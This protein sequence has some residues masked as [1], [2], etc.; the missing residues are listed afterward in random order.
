MVPVLSCSR[1]S[2][3]AMIGGAIANP[4][5]DRTARVATAAPTSSAAGLV[6]YLNPTRYRIRHS[7]TVNRQDAAF[8]Y[9][10]AWLPVPVSWPE[11][12]ISDLKITPDTPPLS[13]TDCRDKVAKWYLDQVRQLSGDRL[14]FQLEYTCTRYAVASDLNQLRQQ[15]WQPYDA[16]APEVKRYLK[17]EARVQSDQADLQAIA[18]RYVG[19]QRPW[20]EVAFNLYTWVLNHVD[21][22][23]VD[24]FKGAAWCFTE[25][26]G[27]C[28]DYSALFVALC[29]AAGIP[30][31]LCPGFHLTDR[32]NEYHVWAEFLLPTGE[33]IPVDASLGDLEAANRL[34][35]FGNL[36]NKRLAVVKTADLRLPGQS[37]G[38]DHVEF[39]QAGAVWW[40]IQHG[41]PA[42]E[43]N[44][45]R[46]DG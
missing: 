30:A 28:G 19:H 20:G 15:P 31:R 1:R 18:A 32:P 2:A 36:N 16:E 11:Q 5:A 43:I 24:G 10:E 8:N 42:F 35:Y 3:L 13:A 21:Y 38:H 17:P 14:E 7:I 9:L 34:Q 4:F 39:L 12:I 22:K 27:E 25:Q 6:R 44:F 37:R 23:F 45:Q 26:H 41:S 46:I 40:Q 33:W 29:R